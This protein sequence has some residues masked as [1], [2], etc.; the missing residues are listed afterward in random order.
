MRWTAALVC[1]VLMVTSACGASPDTHESTTSTRVRAETGSGLV[2]GEGVV[3]AVAHETNRSQRHRSP[4]PTG[5][6]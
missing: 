6:G 1:L 5:G 4:A 3:P 2:P